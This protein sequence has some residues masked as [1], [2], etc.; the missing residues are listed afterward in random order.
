MKKKQSKQALVLIKSAE[1]L[2]SKIA[3]AIILAVKLRSEA[4]FKRRRKLFQK[5]KFEVTTNLLVHTQ[6]CFITP[7]IRKHFLLNHLVFGNA[8]VQSDY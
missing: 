8:I 3:N 6:S 7:N 4:F 1:L 2:A 5:A